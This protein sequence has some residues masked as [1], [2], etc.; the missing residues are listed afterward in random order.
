MEVLL[1]HEIVE[2]LAHLDGLWRR[3]RAPT[4][5]RF[6]FLVS[7]ISCRLFN[8][9]SFSVCSFYFRFAHLQHSD[10]TAAATW[11]WS[12]ELT[13][14]LNVFSLLFHNVTS[15]FAWT[16][17]PTASVHRFRAQTIRLSNPSTSIRVLRDVLKRLSQGFFYQI[18]A[19]TQQITE[20]SLHHSFAL[21][22]GLRFARNAA[23]PSR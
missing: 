6:S 10:G 20:Q 14:T 13:G 23:V 18:T 8:L 19:P 17:H 9:V 11:M 21:N 22:I 7:T 12:R 4:F 3:S 2:A 1:G 15:F 5:G 16:S